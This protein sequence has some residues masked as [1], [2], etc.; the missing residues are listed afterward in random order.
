MYIQTWLSSVTIRRADCLLWPSRMGSTVC[1]SSLPVLQYSSTFRN[2]S[3]I[4]S[5]IPTI[6]WTYYKPKVING[7]I[8]HNIYRRKYN[9]FSTTLSRIS[10]YT[11]MILRLSRWWHYR[12]MKYN[13][14]N[15]INNLICRNNDIPFHHLRKNYIQPTNTT[16]HT[17]TRNSIK[18]S[19]NLQATVPLLVPHCTYSHR[20]WPCLN[21]IA[22]TISFLSAS[23]ILTAL[24]TTLLKFSSAFFSFQSNSSVYFS[25]VHAIWCAVS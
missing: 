11:T 12:Y 18:C 2:H 9:A 15:R 4:Y 21:P 14:I 10:W 22:R 25:M 24:R 20:Q 5:M 7:P 17:Y 6:Y 23:V 1:F 3:T 16:A 8:C 13:F 19:Q